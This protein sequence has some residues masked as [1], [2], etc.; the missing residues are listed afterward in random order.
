M[1]IEDKLSQTMRRATADEPLPADVWDG[2]QRRAHR[3]QRTR[4]AMSAGGLAVAIALAAVIVPKL[5]SKDTPGGFAAPPGWQTY[6]NNYYGYRLRFPADWVATAAASDVALRPLAASD[7]PSSPGY[8]TLQAGWVERDYEYSLA[9][10]QLSGT[11][12]SRR[13]SIGIAP[14]IRRSSEKEIEYV[15]GWGRNQ[16]LV[17]YATGSGPLVQPRLAT[18]E[19]IILT[20][21]EC[22]CIDETLTWQTHTEK[23]GS[24]EIKYPKDWKYGLFEGYSEVEPAELS[25]LAEGGP[26]FAISLFVQPERFDKDAVVCDGTN[27]GTCTASQSS[28]DMFDGRSF[29]AKDEGISISY[30]VD[31]GT[32]SAPLTLEVRMQA[33]SRDL[34]DQ[35]LKTGNRVLRTIHHL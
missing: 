34:W 6:E 23:N 8:F 33:T 25:G 18:A 16:S 12:M 10:P 24:W 35:Y 28:E 19:R 15:V 11:V 14:Y 1:R 2:F 20:L 27:A 17:F 22:A 9:G 31:W 21:Q 29:I 7:S 13:G 32:A 30:R 5:M 26:T 4:V 3:A